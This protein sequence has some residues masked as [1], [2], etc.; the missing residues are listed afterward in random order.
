MKPHGSVARGQEGSERLVE[1]GGDA[2]YL[3]RLYVCGSTWRSAQAIA[4]VKRI[5]EEHLG[6]RYHLEIVDLYQQP[7]LAA[8]HQIVAA[9]TLIKARPAPL[10]RIIGDMSERDRLLAGLNLQRQDPGVAKVPGVP[11]D[12]GR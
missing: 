5:C 10:R 6:G 3:L 8:S 2:S 7:E 11:K 1:R 12:Q 4:N 9:P